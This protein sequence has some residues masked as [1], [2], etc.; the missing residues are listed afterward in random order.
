M[1]L[2]LGGHIRE[3]ALF[4]LCCVSLLIAGPVLVVFLRCDCLLF[5]SLTF[6]FCLFYFR[7]ISCGMGAS[8]R[9]SRIRHCSPWFHIW[10]ILCWSLAL[11]TQ[12]I[13]TAMGGGNGRPGHSLNWVY[14]FFQTVPL[15]VA[16]YLTE[17][18]E[19]AVLKGHS[20]SVIESAS[21][22]IRWGYRLAGMDS[23]TIH[24]LVKG[25]VEGAR[26]KLAR[27]VQPKQPLKHDSIAE[28]ALP[29]GSA[30]ASLAEIRFLFIL[31]VGY[32]GVFRISEVLSIRVR[33][34][35]I[36]DDFMKVY[37]MKR[38]NDQ[39]RDG[40]VSVIA[41]SRKPTCPVGITDRI[42]SLLPDSS[43]SSYP[44]VRRIVSSRHSKE[45]FH[46]P[47]GISYS[48]AYASFKSGIS[49]FVSYTCLYGTHS[50]R[51]GGVN[52]PGS[53]RRARQS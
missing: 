20:A 49:P 30:S 13:S 24:P 7:K 50:I 43:D 40:H 37:L 34:V 31:L 1:L 47:L 5:F 27:P 23:P 26:R 36:L 39:Y 25:V 45:R 12:L 4:A 38:K 2:T 44:I 15:Q 17:L 19:R 29:L 35:T 6:C 16:L 32:A 11:Q 14:L 8:R 18:V 28:I 10:L 41:R 53:S 3:V 46:E 42:L 9:F 51:I 22:S 33:Y 48:T 52:D 21:Y